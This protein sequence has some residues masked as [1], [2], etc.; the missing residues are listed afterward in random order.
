MFLHA[1]GAPTGVAMHLDL[2]IFLEASATVRVE[3]FH[4][5]GCLNARLRQSIDAS[6]WFN[7]CILIHHNGNAGNIQ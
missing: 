4:R 7:E 3:Q 2:A 5:A 1:P 6:T